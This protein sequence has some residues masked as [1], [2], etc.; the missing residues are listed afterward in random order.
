MKYAEIAV[1]GNRDALNGSHR[2]IRRSFNFWMTLLFLAALTGIAC[3]SPTPTAPEGGRRYQVVP[4]RSRLKPGAHVMISLRDEN[5]RTVPSRYSVLE[6]DGGSVK[7]TGE[8]TAPNTSG[9]YHIIASPINSPGENETAQVEVVPYRNSIDVGPELAFS[10]LGHTSTILNDGTV[11]VLGGMESAKVE[12]LAYGSNIPSVVTELPERRWA[13]SAIAINENQI[14]V[15][16]GCGNSGV[17]AGAL[18]LKSSGE[19]TPVGSLTIPRMSF[20]SVQLDDG[21]VLIAGGL[22]AQGSDVHALASVEIY[23]P[24]TKGFSP[25]GMMSVPRTGH[26]VTR[27]QDGKV[28]IVGGRDSTCVFNCP[29]RVWDSLEIFDPGPRTFKWVGRMAQARHGHTATLLPDGRVVIAGGITPDLP[30]TDITSSVEIFDPISLTISESM[31]LLHPRANHTATLLTNNS[32]LF[33]FGRTFGEGTM[34]SSTCE[35]HDFGKLKILT[36]ASPIST[37]FKHTAT[38]LP[39]GRILLIGGSEGGAGLRVVETYE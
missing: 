3:G 27:L 4:A 28:L 11:L 29:E 38:P 26:T 10:R 39:D 34:A 6:V 24:M 32:I 30:G 37:R 15:S 33:A 14:L 16:G 5:N 35:V 18:V 19:S 13:H 21:K 9:T 17:T 2:T 22:P 8:Y 25:V 31:S 36:S 23:D 20:E 12:R 7:D 1:S